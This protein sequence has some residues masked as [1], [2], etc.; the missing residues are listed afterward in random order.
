MGGD[1]L[2]LVLGRKGGWEPVS[3]LGVLSTQ[4]T[5]VAAVTVRIRAYSAT[6]ELDI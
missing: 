2:D 4:F 6:G 3:D 5:G 1:Q